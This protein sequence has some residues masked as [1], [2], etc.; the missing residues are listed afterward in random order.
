M[1][2]LTPAV[3]GGTAFG[4]PTRPFAFV[5]SIIVLFS[6][7]FLGLFITSSNLVS[8]NDVIGNGLSDSLTIS[9]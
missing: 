8:E 1:E 2:G 5:G 7:Q 4:L 9:G 6:L 3:P